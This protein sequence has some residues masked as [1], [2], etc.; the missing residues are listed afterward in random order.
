MSAELHGHDQAISARLLTADAVDVSPSRQ[1]T[2]LAVVCLTSGL[3][4]NF[5]LSGVRLGFQIFR[6]SVRPSAVHFVVCHVAGQWIGWAKDE[7]NT[8]W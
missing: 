6:P 4:H 7:S 3:K 2:L 1:N 5:R 8:G